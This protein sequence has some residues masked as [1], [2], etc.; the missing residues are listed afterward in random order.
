MENIDFDIP[1]LLSR[2]P[3]IGGLA[4]LGIES[5]Q[6]YNNVHAL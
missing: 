3:L 6:L 4:A 2:V 1:T 5:I